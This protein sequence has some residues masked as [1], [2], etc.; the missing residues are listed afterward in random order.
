[1]KRLLCL[2]ACLFSLYAQAA[3]LSLP[4]SSV[5]AS[6]QPCAISA[7]QAGKIARKTFGG[8]VIDIKAVQHKGR[9]VFR[10]KLLQKN[11]RIH[12]VLI[13]ANSGQP[14]K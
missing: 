6:V 5:P 8:K 10:V 1:M 2:T 12:S 9:A 3:P 7:A 4:P 13:D 11:G 14:L